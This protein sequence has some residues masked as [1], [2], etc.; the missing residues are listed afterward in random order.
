[1]YKNGKIA[2]NQN[3][4]LRFLKNGKNTNRLGVVISKKVSKKAVKRNKLRRQIKAYFAQI[5]NNLKTGYDL[6]INVKPTCL[7]LSY[8]KLTKS[9]NY[10]LKK[11]GLIKKNN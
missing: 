5:S 7:D 2:S 11:K 6:L 3:F 1:M 8:Q 10:L 4:T 9:I